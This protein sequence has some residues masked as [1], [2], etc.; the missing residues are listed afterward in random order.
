MTFRTDNLLYQRDVTTQANQ[1]GYFMFRGVI[2]ESQ[3]RAIPTD[4]YTLTARHNETGATI[5]VPGAFDGSF[6]GNVALAGTA[7]AS[8]SYS[9][10]Y[11]PSLVIDAN[12]S[13]SW[14]T[15]Y[16][17][18]S[19]YGATPF[20]EVSLPA[21][22]AVTHVN[23]R[24]NAGGGND[25]LR[26]R[27]ELF[28]AF[29]SVL[30][31]EDF[32][33]PAPARTIELDVPDQEGVRRVRFTGLA[34]DTTH[35]GISELEVIGTMASA[36][37]IDQHNVVL[38]N[39]AT[40]KGRVLRNGGGAAS[41]GYVQVQNGPVYASSVIAADGSYVLTGLTPG[42][43]SITA[44]V[45]HPNCCSENQV[46]VF[47]QA[48]AGQTATVDITLLP[49]GNLTGTVRHADGTPAV[50]VYVEISNSGYYYYTYTDGNGV[51]L[52]P[53]VVAGQYQLYVQEP[54]TGI[55]VT[56]QVA[57][58]AS[59]TTTAD[60]TFFAL[61]SVNLLVQRANGAAAPGSLVYIS[62]AANGFEHAG[63][64][65]SSG[66]IL[67]PF[68]PAG[69]FTIRA[70]VPANTSVY[71][72]VAGQLDTNG[73]VV[74][75]T[76]T[77]P[78]VG[79]VTGRVTYANG[80][81]VQYYCNVQFFTSGQHFAN[82]CTD[83][84]GVYNFE[85]GVQIG[86]QIVVRAW[87]P[88]DSRVYRQTAAF[89]LDT[90][91]ETRVVDF[92][93]PAFAA[94]RVTVLKADGTPMAGAR[95]H[96]RDEFRTFFSNY[97][98]TNSSGQ[99]LI[100]NQPEGQ[101]TVRVLDGNSG[102][103]LLDH[104]VTM[105]A[106]D[107]GLTIDVVIQLNLFAGA[108]Q[109]TVQ[110]SDGLAVAG[111]FVEVLNA[112]DL[113]RLAS[114]TTGAAGAYSFANVLAGNQGV[115]VRAHAPNDPDVI[116]DRTHTFS[117]VGQ[118]AQIDLPLPVLRG[119]INGQVTSSGGI[120]LPSVNVQ[121]FAA[122]NMNRVLA[123]TY[124]DSNGAF[125]FDGLYVR[126]GNFVVRARSSV[127][128]E[129]SGAF[130]ASDVAVPVVIQIPVRPTQFSV[131]VTAADAATGIP[132]IYAE[133]YSTQGTYLGA[134]YTDALG[135]AN[136]GTPLL[137]DNVLLNVYYNQYP[138]YRQLQ[139]PVAV[140]PDGAMQVAVT[141]PLS[142]VRGHVTFNDG[143]SVSSLNVV[144]RSPGEDDGEGGTITRS[145]STDGQ[146]NYLV[147]GPP[148]GAIEV[149]AQ[150][151]SSGLSTVVDAEVTSLQVPVTVNVTLPPTGSIRARVLSADGTP[152]PD[153]EVVLL[154]ANVAFDR[155]E[156]T[157]DDGVVTFQHVPL[158]AAALQARHYNGMDN[159]FAS[160]GV[161]LIDEGV[162]VAID[163]RF[164]SL[165]TLRGTITD[166]AGAPVADAEVHIESFGSTGPLG[167]FNAYPT[168]DANGRYE[169]Q[170]PA[171]VVH[172][173]AYRYDPELGQY[174]HG[175]STT[176]VPP[177]GA[178]LDVR[179]ND[180]SQFNV[181]L[182]GA[183]GFRYDIRSDGAVSDGGLA[184]RTITDAYDTAMELEI[185]GDE[186]CCSD[187]PR[188][189]LND[190]Q[191]VTGPSQTASMVVTR[192]VFV[193]A[194]GGFARYLEQISN[195]TN[196]ARSLRVRVL[197]DVGAGSTSRVAV[198]P[199]STSNTYAVTNEDPDDGG[200]RPAIAHVFNGPGAPVT[201]TA[202]DFR[203]FEDDM[204]YEWHVVVPPGQTIAILH[205][206]A[207]RLTD[208]ASG[209]AAAVAQAQALV[210]LS[211]PQALEGLTPLE[212]SQIVNFV[213]PNGSDSR[214]SIEGTIFAGDGA[215]PLP[216]AL[217][218]AT[219]PLTGFVIAAATT[220]AD[221]R[222]AFDN[223]PAAPQ[224][225]LLIAHLPFSAAQPV[226]RL[227]EFGGGNT[228]TGANITIGVSVLLGRVLG[229]A[230][231]PVANASVIGSIVQQD[232]TPH[233]FAATAD[234]NGSYQVFGLPPGA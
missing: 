113:V 45:P 99:R 34:D 102:I 120:P 71:V 184:N 25:F 59:Q 128:V 126:D 7:R 169:R 67:I 127:T 148:I 158:G 150:D 18:S 46:T 61:G 8:S 76:A 186:F 32:D 37:G 214:G 125:T 131:V 19:S 176:L 9:S 97:G 87:H 16:L 30:H 57:L 123:S 168:T 94:V 86:Q 3:S 24:G 116:V 207:Q 224:G 230:G 10:G 17:Q 183:D 222:Y 41:S 146:G 103:A 209:E 163:L 187:W 104:V 98:T 133:L 193:P 145:A 49:T 228:V 89:A 39:T 12:T 153:V 166:A 135:V 56:R 190:R 118:T 204:F 157:D 96:A 202:T 42:Q 117:G 185:D 101:V 31:T 173:E 15:E 175:Y 62:R 90:D 111:S 26:G 110:T 217:V 142:I 52:L 58:P 21:A 66:R 35:P 147:F 130:T 229:L 211:D 100:S 140:E 91:G 194:A 139:V 136:F 155:Y 82:A 208:P 115:I 223:L 152:Q 36:S 119:R 53:D 70:H 200:G 179:L 162:T 108:I 233:T 154:S 27:I 77:L 188:F 72:D 205:F 203:D 95:I 83:G 137:P 114:M 144:V 43:Y 220:Q 69:A 174:V 177:G 181:N 75:M 63:Y 5:T 2:L 28:D 79:S 109:G 84:N 92:T 93:L 60:V 80:T 216:E 55:P 47:V 196:V 141:F 149:V 74:P 73:Q 161:T 172:V 151:G 33:L 64:T 180:S 105:T 164:P 48:V 195:P 14:Y 88:N 198:S 78:A 106:A 50:S 210:S 68:V 160:G 143:T 232:G 23:I 121:V 22:A 20:I 38:T 85:S 6:T 112:A 159:V 54:N 40:I 44:R 132:N 129:Q 138:D 29:D 122:T 156:Y 234:A 226:S 167:N 182:D 189:E 11:P 218:Q 124:T 206:T 170:I 65:D 165:A 13:T 107:N 213:I 51:Y 134:A 171:G 199:A 197:T 81:P 191:V 212:Q 215:T 225:I 201:V 221:G 227:V 231:V 192:K 178:T 1:F 4:T 219:D